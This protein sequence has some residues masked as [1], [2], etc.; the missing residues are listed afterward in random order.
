MFQLGQAVFE[1]GE[2]GPLG[3]F[4]GVAAEYV[5]DPARC[6]G[7]LH[8]DQGDISGEA[9]GQTGDRQIVD[10]ARS[11]RG[12]HDEI[13]AIQPAGAFEFADCQGDTGIQVRCRI[14]ARVDPHGAPG[15]CRHELAPLS[16]QR[17][18]GDRRF[19]TARKAFGDRPDIR[20]R[21][22]GARVCGPPPIGHRGEQRDLERQ[23]RDNRQGD[24]SRPHRPSNQPPHHPR[25]PDQR[26]RHKPRRD[27]TLDPVTHPDIRKPHRL[28]QPVLPPVGPHPRQPHH[29]SAAHH[30]HTAN[31]PPHRPEL[32]APQHNS[33][34]STHPDEQHHQ[35]PG[36]HPLHD[37][38][39]RQQPRS[40]RDHHPRRSGNR[41]AGPR[42]RKTP[43]R[44]QQPWSRRGHR[45][46]CGGNR[47]VGSWYWKTP[48]RQQ[49]PW[50]RRGHRLRCGGNRG[51]GSW[52]WKTPYRQQ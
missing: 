46:R 20:G 34:T 40:Q 29:Q 16:S 18:P 5:A 17:G 9:P 2:Q 43:Y 11:G 19:A 35:H 48:Y 39:S 3:A 28:P 52:Y 32:P 33:H 26:T 22:V 51:V 10:P 49:R 1:R 13:R 7:V 36:H 44:Q 21:Y 6:V 42:Q 45:L 41:G 25:T 50:S 12:H 24:A 4:G 37:R 38:C 14:Q 15:R 27:N 30:D 23:R 31:P 47:G 8:G